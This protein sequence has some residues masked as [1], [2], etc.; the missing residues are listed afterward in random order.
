MYMF[1]YIVL[2]LFL[3]FCVTPS[4]SPPSLFSL[5]LPPSLSSP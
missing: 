5:P 3:F 4:I 2:P 1:S